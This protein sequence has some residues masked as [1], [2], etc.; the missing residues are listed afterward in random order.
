M[1]AVEELQ[2]FT[3]QSRKHVNMTT[4]SWVLHQYCLSG[5]NGEKEEIHKRTDC[6]LLQVRYEGA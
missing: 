5:Q 2:K 1:V 4:I 3:A 6:S